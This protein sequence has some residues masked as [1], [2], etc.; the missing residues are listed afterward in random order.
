MRTFEIESVLGFVEH[1]RHD[2][3]FGQVIYRGQSHKRDLL[4][5]VARAK[6]TLNSTPLEK[7]MLEQVRLMAGGLLPAQPMDDLELMIL[8]QHHGLKTRLLDWSTS[9]LVALW[10]ACQSGSNKQDAYV[11]SLDCENIATSQR[12][13]QDPFNLE[14]TVVF[15][16]A[17]NNSRMAAQL[18]WFSLHNYSKDLGQFVALESDEQLASNSMIEYRI[19]EAIKRIILIELDLLGFNSKTLYPD[20]TGLCSYVNGRYPGVI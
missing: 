14:K 1:V 9:P 18:G 5:G 20:L 12:L 15:Q 13:I 3:F 6:P 17:V 2:N 16:P 7:G 8:A 4:P 10:F 19:P 11:Y